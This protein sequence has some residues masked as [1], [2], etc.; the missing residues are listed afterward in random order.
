MARKKKSSA[1]PAERP[2]DQPTASD[3]PA[4]DREGTATDQLSKACRAAL[5]AYQHKDRLGHPF[6]KGRWPIALVISHA[7]D[8]INGLVSVNRAEAIKALKGL[9]KIHPQ[10]HLPHRYL[11][12]QTVSCDRQTV[13]ILRPA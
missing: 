8:F 9:T 2:V 13:G 11:V 1:A 6:C 12:R 5:L 4:A 10:A 3:I 7:D